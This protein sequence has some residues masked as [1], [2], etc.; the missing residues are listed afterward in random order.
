MNNTL[1]G[2]HRL[3]MALAANLLLMSCAD[4]NRADTGNPASRE[5]GIP[6]IM[7][8]PVFENI[9]MDGLVWMSEAPGQPGVW[10][11]V[12]KPGR[13]LRLERNNNEYQSSLFIDITD[14]V[15]DGP[16]E[17]GLLGM[18]FHPQY[19]TNGYV[20]LSYTGN[21]GGLVSYISRFGV[22]ES[23]QRLLPGSEK[24]LLEVPQPYS[25]HNGGQITFGPDGFLYIGLG[26]GGAGGDPQGNGQNTNTLLGALLR[27]DVDKGD[28]YGIPASNPFASGEQ[29][30]P[31]IY[32][33]GLRNPWRWSFDRDTGH[34]WLA[35]VGQNAWEE[36]DLVSEPGNF[37]WNGKEGTHCY[38]SR[39]C[40]NPAFIDPVVEYSHEQGC[41]VTGGYVYRG[42][43]LPA[44]Q[45][46]YLYSDFC[47]GTLWGARAKDNGEYETFNLLESGL[48][49]A[50][51][52]QGQDGELYVLHIR[53]DIYR[54]AGK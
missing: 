44:L 43:A 29:G 19:A 16:N 2:W 40:D 24:R 28:P 45:G 14:R 34:I 31:E 48:N 38:E 13:V 10:Y 32:A 47:S 15:D 8:Q 17:A 20:Y 36:V 27:V 11:V 50:S 54:I 46:V 26:D 22:D 5:A 30:R 51:F 3:L 21:N 42:S 53:G 35:D 41:S 37:G 33:W 1:T 7:L 23:G 39:R 6:A 4:K 18:A 12:E 25:N 49:I 9:S 52:A